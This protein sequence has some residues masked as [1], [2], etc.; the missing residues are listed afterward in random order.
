ME[1]ISWKFDGLFKGD[2]EKCYAECE[3]LEQA[4][5][6][7]VLELAKD[8]T[9]ELHKCFEWDNDIAAEKYRLCQAREIIR[10]FVIV[11]VEE[12]EHHEPIRAFQITTQTSVYQPTRL[13][14]QDKDEYAELLA[15]AKAELAAFRK[16]YATLC[17]LESVFEEIDR[18]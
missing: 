18:L 9:T 16:R 7:N 11:P 6:E 8:D 5:P 1:R 3:S 17:E 10:S 12:S 2:A 4:T 15:R 13:F 14:L